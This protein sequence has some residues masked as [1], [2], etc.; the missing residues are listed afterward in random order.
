MYD[1]ARKCDVL[2]ENFLPGKLDQMNVGY[3]KLKKINPRLIYCA[4]TGFGPTGPY[5]NKP[6]YVQN[7]LVIYNIFRFTTFSF[8]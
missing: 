4:I 5:A 2:V 3:E 6:G 8:A 7:I 1:L